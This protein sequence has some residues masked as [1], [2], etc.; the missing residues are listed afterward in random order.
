M[1][2][3]IQVIHWAAQRDTK[4]TTRY[5]QFSRLQGLTRRGNSYSIEYQT[6]QGSFGLIFSRTNIM[7][8]VTAWEI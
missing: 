6:T 3:I 4:S 7:N 2:E 8:G 5:K 1:Q